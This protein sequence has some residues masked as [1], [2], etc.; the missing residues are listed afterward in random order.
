[1]KPTEPLLWGLIGAIAATVLAF[2]L[3]WAS[4]PSDMASPAAGGFFM[5]WV[6][7]HLWN[8]AGKRR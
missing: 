2:V 8:W 5:G 4:I 7:G 6:S 1:M 3:A